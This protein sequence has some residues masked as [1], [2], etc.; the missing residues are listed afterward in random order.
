ML[1][2][3]PLAHFVAGRRYAYAVSDR[4]CFV[5][6]FVGGTCTTTLAGVPVELVVATDYPWDGKVT[7]SVHPKRAVE[8]ALNLRLPEWCR[9]ATLRLNG[10]PVQPLTSVRTGMNDKDVIGLHPLTPL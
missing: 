4:E 6:L 2:A 3:Q 8:F 1:P 5:N 9:Q 7:L 10:E